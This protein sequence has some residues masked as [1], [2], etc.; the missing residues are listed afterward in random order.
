MPG[1]RRARTARPRPGPHPCRQPA[2]PRNRETSGCGSLGGRARPAGAV[3]PDLGDAAAGP[4]VRAGVHAAPDLAGVAGAVPEHQL[5][6]RATA[7][8][9]PA[10]VRQGL[11]GGASALLVVTGIAPAMLALAP[12]GLR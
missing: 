9:R 12:G 2:R 8:P 7:K 5:A 6:V 11:G 1:R 4:A 3:A 10:A